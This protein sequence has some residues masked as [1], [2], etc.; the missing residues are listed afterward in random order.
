M[1][2][3][4]GALQQE[5]PIISPSSTPNPE[6]TQ[7]YKLPVMKK[8]CEGDESMVGVESNSRV[9]SGRDLLQE[10]PH[11]Q[12]AILKMPIYQTHKN[13]TSTENS[14]DKICREIAK[15]KVAQNPYIITM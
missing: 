9:C 10:P 4:S 14:I 13:S 6:N 1:K 12:N 3:G 5:L 7:G 2:L 11:N 15:L 8:D